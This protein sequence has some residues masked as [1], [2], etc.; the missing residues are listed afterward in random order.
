MLLTTVVPYILVSDNWD[1]NITPRFMRSDHQVQS[2]HYVNSYGVQDRIPPP[3]DVSHIKVDSKE[4]PLA[5]FLLNEDDCRTLRENY[6]FLVARVL[7]EKCDFFFKLKKCVPPH[8]HHKY[9]NAMS[10]KSEIVRHVNHC[11]YS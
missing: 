5:T 9:F 3:C 8:L 11:M 7:V 1:K 2:L 4:L 6:I 10:K